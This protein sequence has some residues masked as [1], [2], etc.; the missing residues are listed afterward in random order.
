LRLL[1]LLLLLLGR[2]QGDMGLLRRWLHRLR[3]LGSWPH[4]VCPLP[5][6]AVGLDLLQID[7]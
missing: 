3:L 4:C 6:L 1:L 7:L 5:L 2:Q